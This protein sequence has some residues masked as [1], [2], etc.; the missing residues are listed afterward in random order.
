MAG[1]NIACGKKLF[2]QFNFF[3]IK[4]VKRYSIF[5][6]NLFFIFSMRKFFMINIYGIVLSDYA[7]KYNAVFCNIIQSQLPNTQRST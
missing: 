5:N 6:V 3:F 1:K 7:L 2:F 4:I